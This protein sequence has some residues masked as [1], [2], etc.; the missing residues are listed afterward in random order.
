MSRREEGDRSPGVGTV[1]GCS[2]AGGGSSSASLFTSN[3]YCMVLCVSSIQC[4]RLLDFL[5]SI[6]CQGGNNFRCRLGSICVL[7][8]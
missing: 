1:G 2:G 3:R 7:R 8:S 5:A 6:F 4:S